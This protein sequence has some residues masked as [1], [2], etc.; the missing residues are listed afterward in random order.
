MI[1]KKKKHT[2]PDF[3]KIK[4]T[5][6]EKWGEGNEPWSLSG[7]N[8]VK[9]Y[10]PHVPTHVLKDALAGLDTYTIHRETKLPKLYNPI[11]VR[12]PRELFQA[13]LIE[14][15]KGDY[16][17][18]N[19]GIKYLLVVIDSFTRFA[20]I[21]PIKN[22]DAKTVLAAYK[23][24]HQTSK[25]FEKAIL[26]DQGAEFQNHL[27]KKYLSSKNIELR[28]SN[29]KAP[30]VERFNRTFQNLLYRWME[31]HQTHQYVKQIPKLL[32]LY[33][34]RYHR[35]IKMSPAQAEKPEN[36]S[37]VLKAVNAYYMSISTKA[38]KQQGSKKSKFQVGDHVRI[39]AYNKKFHKG[40]YQQFK[41]F[42][43][44]IAEVLSHLPVIM[45]KIR[46]R[47]THQLEAGT[48]YDEELQKVSK[49]YD[50]TVFKIDEIV[51]TDGEGDE[52]QALVKWKYWN[53]EDNTWVPY[54]E[55]KDIIKT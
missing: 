21:E 49:D 35:T 9:R 27:F 6:R 17:T 52:K 33:N 55:I 46:N 3:Q 16:P 20:W 40:Y 50:G 19:N 45:Y 47:H 7:I 53:N 41:P 1:G 23:R 36:Y 38:A 43:Y 18:E 11:Y 10:F 48:W 8:N 34:N 29:D 5:I 14:I 26:T 44:E 24:I 13:D 39:S 31:E 54:S 51:D 28:K 32:K 30:H 37:K 25:P 22:K 2:K 15:S 12:K 42:V 4:R